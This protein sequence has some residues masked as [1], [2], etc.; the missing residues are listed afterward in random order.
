MQHTAQMNDEVFFTSN[1]MP[2]TGKTGRPDMPQTRHSA[3]M[4][5]DPNMLH[6]AQ[7]CVAMYIRRLAPTVVYRLEQGLIYALKSARRF[8]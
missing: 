6:Y 4:N 7:D 3:R 5:P 1:P 2:S 8:G